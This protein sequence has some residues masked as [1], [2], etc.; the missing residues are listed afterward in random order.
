MRV[1]LFVTPGSL[2]GSF[3]RRPQKLRMRRLQPRQDTVSQVHGQRTKFGDFGIAGD[4]GGLV[5]HT[6][7]LGA[8]HLQWVGNLPTVADGQTQG[9]D[10]AHVRAAAFGRL[11]ARGLQRQRR[12]LKSGVVCDRK[13]PVTVQI[14]I[15]AGCQIPLDD[16]Q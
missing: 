8:K 15:S 5:D 12:A 11:E 14:G 4:S 10:R 9:L 1:A 16:G 7:A 2:A 6:A 13:S 3:W